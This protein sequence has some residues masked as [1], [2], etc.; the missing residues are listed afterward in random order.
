MRSLEIRLRAKAAL[1]RWDRRYCAEY[2][3]P[4]PSNPRVRRF[5]MRG[6]AL[7]LVPTATTNGV[8]A[9]SSFHKLGRAAD[10]GLRGPEVGTD[11]GKRR[12]NRFQRREFG[13]RRRLHH[14]ELIGPINNR[15][16]LMGKTTTL[17]EGSTLEQAHDNH[18][19]GAF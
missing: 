7:G 4:V 6:F 13:N 18:V 5:I 16:I 9:A 12:L 10:M 14:I 2:H 19:H 8:H 1:G 3:V 15:V 17:P 11:K